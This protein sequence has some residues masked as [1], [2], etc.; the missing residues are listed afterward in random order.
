MHLYRVIQPVSDIEAAASFYSMVFGTAGERV[1]AGRHYFVCGSTIL[2]CYDPTADGDE[3]GAG[4]QPHPNQYL[5]FSTHNLEGTLA[6]VREAGGSIDAPIETMPWGE[7]MFYA[8]DPFGNPISFVDQ[9]TL[10][11]GAASPR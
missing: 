2:A 1:S 5:Y 10:F 7:R 3:I 9:G 4:W 8:K 11:L 6:L